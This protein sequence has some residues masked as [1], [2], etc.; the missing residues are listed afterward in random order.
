MILTKPKSRLQQKRQY[1]NSID[2]KEQDNDP[3]REPLVFLCITS[4]P[5]AVGEIIEQRSDLLQL[6]FSHS[7]IFEG[8]KSTGSAY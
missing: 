6:S 3:F 1:L 2:C 7:K 5:T 8:T 4:Y